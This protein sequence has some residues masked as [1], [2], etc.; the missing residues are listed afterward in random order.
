MIVRT[1]LLCLTFLLCSAIVAPS[2]AQAE[3]W[4]QW[5][6]KNRDA[7]LNETGLMDSLPEGELP[8][9]WTVPIGSGYTGPTVANGLVYVMDR[10]PRGDES[11]IER[12][13]CFDAETGQEV[14]KH[15]Y[16]SQYTIGYRAGPRASV[17]IHDGR[18]Y[19]VGAMGHFH[20]Y[21][22]K[23]GDVLWSHDLATK[24]DI[25]MP[26]WGI[27]ASPLVYKDLVIQ[28]TGGR[29][30]ACVVA[31]DR[32]TGLHRW[33]S[34]NEL[35]GY[36]APV[37]I[38]QGDQDVVVCWTGESVSG[39]H[40]ESGDVLWRIPMNSKNMPI[41][42]A[43]PVVKNNLIFVSS[44]YDG[45]MLVEFDPDRPQARQLWRR[46]G[47]DERNTDAL[48]C[49]ISTPLIKGDHIYGVDSY[50]ELRCLDL[51]TGDRI[52]EDR[53]AV[54]RNRWATIHTI[55]YGD[56]EIML[57]DQ[58]FLIYAQL[59]P[60]SYKELSRTKLL[61]PTKVQLA[62]RNGVSWAHPAIANGHIFIR[63]DNK[64]LRASLKE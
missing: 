46:V 5:R 25:K 60:E 3:D 35:A 26:V 20:C 36:A 33:R 30:G 53:T 47:V 27:T 24:Y 23:S 57:N 39:L 54:P 10:G 4:P 48:H 55:Q 61:D 41:G 42:V 37:M 45:S 21:D 15:A 17:T 19:A 13:L 44:F 50:G 56:R 59:N 22:A 40:P 43:T 14:W 51:K 38:R 16:D 1:S 63:N 32:K 2:H 29:N 9:T 62:R 58:G 18:A 49:M 52:W 8:R 31:M 34:L 6:G 7:V 28:I 11:Q 64:L 12:V